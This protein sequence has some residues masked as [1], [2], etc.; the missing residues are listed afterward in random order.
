MPVTLLGEGGNSMN[1]THITAKDNKTLQIG[2]QMELKFSSIRYVTTNCRP[3]CR[4]D[5]EHRFVVMVSVRRLRGEMDVE[6]INMYIRPTS[7]QEALAVLNFFHY[8]IF[9]FLR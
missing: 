6:I 8:H 5:P 1:N 2:S 7:A 9:M 3:L 4:D